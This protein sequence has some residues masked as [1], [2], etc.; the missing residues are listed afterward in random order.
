MSTTPSYD[1]LAA[2]N[3]RLHHFAHLGSIT[4]WDQETQMPPKGNDA[5]GAA[6]AELA[7]LMHRPQ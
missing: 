7:A 2:D 3:L 5:R 1:L 6:L 4:R